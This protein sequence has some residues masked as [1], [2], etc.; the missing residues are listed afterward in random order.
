MT[1]V[2][3]PKPK[4]PGSIPPCL[5]NEP[6]ELL[7]GGRKP[8]ASSLPQLVATYT[9]AVEVAAVPTRCRP[10]FRATRG[11]NPGSGGCSAGGD[12]F[13]KSSTKNF[14]DSGVGNSAASAAVTASQRLRHRHHHWIEVL[15]S[16]NQR[17]DV[18]AAQLELL[19]P[20][21][22]LYRFAKNHFSQIKS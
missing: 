8:I 22:S 21:D 18:L 19:P 15:L 12:D 16:L 14:R 9:T 17:L 5:T 10:N 13:R 4:V 11:R 3:P 20:S 7:D 1:Q 2:N 6:N